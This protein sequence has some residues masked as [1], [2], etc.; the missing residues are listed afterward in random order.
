MATREP[1]GS[2]GGLRASWSLLRRNPDFRRLY[3]ASLISLGGDWF[4]LVA[5]FG[6][7]I[8]LTGQAIAVAFTLAA[9]DLTYFVASPVAGYLADRLDRRRLMV[10]T[11]VARAGLC[12]GF[13]LVRSEPMVWLVYVLLAAMA[14]FSA[15][16]EPASLAAVP[17]LVESR[18]LSTANALTG[19]LW[20]TMLAVGAALGGLVAAGLGRDA[21]ILIDAGTFAVSAVLIVRIGGAFAE[22][23]SPTTTPSL[24]RDT[25][26]TAR[27]ARKDHR[28]LALIAVKFGWGVAGGVLVL[29]P[30]L[31]H[32]SFHAGD[33]GLGLL[34][35]ARGVGAVIGP[36]VARAALGPEDRRL[37]GAIGVALA[38]FGVGY[39]LL[40]LAPGLL[41]A[42]PV[43]ALAHVGGGAQWTL[44]SYGLQRIVP[45]RIRGRIF[46]FDGMLVTLTFGLSSVL[47]GVLADAVGPQETALLLGA[48]AA[49]WAL[50]W[51]WFTTD[52]RRVTLLEGCRPASEL[53]PI[54]RA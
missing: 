26:E 38:T 17:N 42:M 14:T 53:E 43:V 50:L 47:T 51:S 3:L 39:A 27:Y 41:L 29:I 5:L 13:L 22:S 48:F 33:I 23:R 25:I 1:V 37:F 52:L 6:L 40:G 31:A 4:L 10:A 21:A 34:M 54:A 11:D 49:A 32:E 12:V 15:A 28:V 2:E 35:A 46:A 24:R 7:V 44:S 20:G 16:F 30:V 18:D 36:F 8:E 19:S 45:D 9:Q